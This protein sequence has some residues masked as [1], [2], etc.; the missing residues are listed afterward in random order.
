MLGQLFD[1][2]FVCGDVGNA[3]GSG[4]GWYSH[5]PARQWPVLQSE[6]KMQAKFTSHG[7]HVAPPQS[8]SVSSP[9]SL[10]SVQPTS[11]GL[12]VG[13]GVGFGV[14]LGTGNVVGPGVES[15]SVGAEVLAEY[16]AAAKVAGRVLGSEP[17]LARPKAPALATPLEAGSV[18]LLANPSANRLAHLRAHPSAVMWAR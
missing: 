10:S 7:G 8:T 4:E 6:S 1:V 2:K 9:L 3:V 12:G 15:G 13:A 17:R 5:A 11:V 16:W 18:E 14:G